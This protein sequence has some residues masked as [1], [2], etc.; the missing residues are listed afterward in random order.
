MSCLIW[1]GSVLLKPQLIY[2]SKE[3][4]P[5]Y[6]NV[7]TPSQETSERELCFVFGISS[8]G[9]QVQLLNIQRIQDFVGCASYQYLLF[10]S[11][12]LSQETQNEDANNS[13]GLS[14]C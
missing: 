14:K 2:L 6:I 11:L 12:V 1:Q 4:C 3:F 9:S 13:L 5:K 10:C 8:A 7:N